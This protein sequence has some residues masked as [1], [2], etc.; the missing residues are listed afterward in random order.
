MKNNVHAQWNFNVAW[1]SDAENLTD[2]FTKHVASARHEQVCKTV[3]NWICKATS[4]L[5]ALW[6]NKTM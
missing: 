1:E 4:W 5:V 2:N 3:M 6:T